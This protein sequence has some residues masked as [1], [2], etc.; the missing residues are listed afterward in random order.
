MFMGAVVALVAAGVIPGADPVERTTSVLGSLFGLMFFSVGVFVSLSDERFKVFHDAWWF[1]LV[2]Y[3]A[4]ITFP[5][6]FLFLFNWVS[7]GPGERE[8]SMSISIPFLSAYSDKSNEILGRI[9]FAIPTLIMDFFVIVTIFIAAK[10][11]IMRWVNAGEEE[12]A[13]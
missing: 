3:A 8:F 11:I 9:I 5:G 10:E 1:K 12:E 7:F 6:I 4:M 13:L 2:L